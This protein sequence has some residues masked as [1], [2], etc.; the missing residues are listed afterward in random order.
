MPI[1][2]GLG[3]PGTSYKETRH[4]VGFKIVENLA[5]KLKLSWTK[6]DSWKAQIAEGNIGGKRILLVKPQTFMN[7][8]GESVRA[9]VRNTPFTPQ[10]I[11]VILDDADIPFGS[12]R[13][14]TEGSS[15]GQ[16]GLKS[17]I[18]S[19]PEENIKR[20]RF[21]IGRPSSEH[22]P[23]DEWVLMPWS[24]EEEKELATLIDKVVEEILESIRS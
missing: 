13:L 21:G 18:E 11:L 1:I 6:K 8:S 2:V 14:R 22:L 19:F 12:W 23:L 24:Q 3:N 5:K 15:G 17:I 7:L 16:K 4:N 9:I 10:D 20:L